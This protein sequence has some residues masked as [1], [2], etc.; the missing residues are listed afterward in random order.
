MDRL[1]KD[2]ILYN[3]FPMLNIPDS[4]R[5]A[6][7][8]RLYNGLK[9]TYFEKNNVRPHTLRQRFKHWAFITKQ[10]RRK[11]NSWRKSRASLPEEKPILLF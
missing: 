2:F 3:V 11:Q 7:T 1:H 6:E 4:M 8:A 10:R 5:I 9:E